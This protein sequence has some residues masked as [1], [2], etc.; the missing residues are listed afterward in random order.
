[1]DYIFLSSKE[2]LHTLYGFLD[3]E[4]IMVN[5]ILEHNIDEPLDQPYSLLHIDSS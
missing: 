5:W 2:G 1:M 3:L 4:L